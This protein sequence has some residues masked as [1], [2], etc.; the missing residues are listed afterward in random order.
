MYAWEILKDKHLNVKILITFPTG[1]MLG[2]NEI[3]NVKCFELFQ[4]KVPDEYK[5][6][7]IVKAIRWLLIH[8]L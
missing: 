4:R 3:T 2:I 1:T 5:W 8:V 6:L 7:L